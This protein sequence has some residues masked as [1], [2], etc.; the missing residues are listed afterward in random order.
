MLRSLILCLLLLTLFPVQSSGNFCH[1]YYG[2]LYRAQENVF[3]SQR[4]ERFPVG[5]RSVEV[6]QSDTASLTGLHPD[7]VEALS[8]AN[9]SFT[10]SRP[11]IHPFH[12]FQ[13]QKTV[14]ARTTRYFVLKHE[15][16]IK[17]L[18]MI[19]DGRETLPLESEFPLTNFRK[20]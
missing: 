2:N 3:N 1:R 17:G 19:V 13:K 7:V 11:G 10:A 18:G 6:F 12:V 20:H 5:D 14:N 15:E 9:Y 4:S 8:V 16:K